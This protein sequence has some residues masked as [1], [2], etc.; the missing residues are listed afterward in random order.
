MNLPFSKSKKERREEGKEEKKDEI[1][2]HGL[3]EKEARAGGRLSISV[4]G[5][6][7]VHILILHT[8]SMLLGKEST[9]F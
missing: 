5:C 9:Y 6:V 3:G 7:A 4:Y 8:I 1:N 2:R